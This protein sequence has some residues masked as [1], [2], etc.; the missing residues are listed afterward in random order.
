MPSPSK[1]AFAAAAV[2]AAAATTV[3]ATCNAANAVGAPLPPTTT[4][5]AYGLCPVGFY[6]PN[7]DINNKSTYPAV[8]PADQHCLA[9]RLAGRVCEAQGTYEPLPCLEGKYC[10]TGKQQLE[11][12]KGSF[13]PLGSW[14][15]HEC[16]GLSSCPAGSRTEYFLGCLLILALV[17]AVVVALVL[18]YRHLKQP[19]PLAD[20]DV[21][22]EQRVAQNIARAADGQRAMNFHF[23]DLKVA[24]S[25]KDKA[26]PGK[27]L[28]SSVSG[29]IH[30]GQVT[31]IMGPSGAGKSVLFN[32]LLGR[33][34]EGAQ[35][36]GT[37]TVNGNTDIKSF[38]PLIGYVPQD[39]VLY[40][41]LSV[42]ENLQYASEVRLPRDWTADERRQMEAATIRSLGLAHVC[43]VRVGDEEQRG[44]SGGQRKRTNIGVELVTAP[45]ALFL[46]EPTTGLDASSA[47]DVCRL[48]KTVAQD[49]NIP[50]AMVVH[51][52]RVEIWESLDQ[53][54]L[55]APGGRTV[56]EGSRE[57]CVRY[58]TDFAKLDFAKGNPCDII[59]D[60]I[61][62]RGDEFADAWAHNVTEAEPVTPFVG[63]VPVAPER[64]MAPWYKQTALAHKRALMVQFE[65][66]PTVGLDV[67]L[68]MVGAAMLST[69]AINSPFAGMLRDEFILV[70]PRGDFSVAA[71]LVMLWLIAMAGSVAP[72]AVRTF[73]NSRTQYWREA[74]SGY[75]RAAF[76]VG[77]LTSEMYRLTL[78]ALHFAVVVYIMWR[79]TMSFGSLFGFILL[80]FFV[81]DSQ[82]VML[83]IILDP[84]TAPLL[85]TVTA[86]FTSLLNGFPT[87]PGSIISYAFWLTNAVYDVESSY[88]RH[89]YNF[90][91]IYDVFG[92]QLHL[93]ATGILIVLFQAL[94][95][96][97]LG[98]LL[99]IRVNRQAQQ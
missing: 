87:I 41:D 3:D 47:L 66:L 99:L 45:A 95:F 7:S 79:P 11:C 40:T 34:P 32:T 15:H 1:L 50:V 51:Q 22:P 76:Y 26:N 44:I 75:S 63:A 53:L 36:E 43:D 8:C 84:Q 52:P 70:S 30:A 97:V 31:A 37:L 78:A 88:T 85:A 21:A 28:L 23:R 25:E 48:L 16:S 12:P 68:G 60:A 59:M 92:Y 10:P 39:D 94:F 73:G 89:M 18:V 42:K 13:C 57:E 4:D 38:R 14:E 67:L 2:M 98:F 9:E 20:D 55:L 54:L 69:A 83:G 72:A 64:P 49:G 27:V 61:A 82:S 65:H 93:L 29:Q 91:V 81:V 6:C 46:D 17:D 90:H 96:R 62:K 86:V 77:N 71:M 19:A 80:A 33:L 74:S 35:V 56:F 58:F 24:L 5:L